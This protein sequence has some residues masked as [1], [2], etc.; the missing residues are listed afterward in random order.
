MKNKSLL[1]NSIQGGAASINM[2]S[3]GDLPGGGII[4]NDISN[5][6]KL[7]K[8]ETLLEQSMKYLKH[9]ESGEKIFSPDSNSILV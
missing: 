6:K 1:Q 2:S 7:K 5:L 4:R 8:P 9:L 3:I